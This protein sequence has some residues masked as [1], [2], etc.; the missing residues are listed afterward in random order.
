MFASNG[1]TFLPPPATNLT[2]GKWTI[3]IGVQIHFRLSSYFALPSKDIH[4]MAQDKGELVLAE[5][6][7]KKAN[8]IDA[9]FATTGPGRRIMKPVVKH[10]IHHP[11]FLQLAMQGSCSI[12]LPWTLRLSLFSS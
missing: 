6:A 10:L 8:Q 9:D 12:W 11:S 1:I 2:T 5:V 4:Y 3:V 7:M